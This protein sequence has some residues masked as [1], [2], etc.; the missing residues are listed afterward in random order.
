MDYAIVRTGGKQYKVSSGDVLDVEKLPASKGDRIELTDV[1]LLSHEG[2]VTV[3]SPT[4][5]GAK[6]IGEVEEQRRGEKLVVFRYKSKTRQGT[7]TGH[8][9]WLTRLRIIEILSG[10]AQPSRRRRRSDASAHFLEA[11]TQPP[12]RRRRSTA[13]STA[14]VEEAKDGP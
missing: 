12:R 9:Q 8:R 1:L 2:S 11:I 5:M 10:G 13:R 14:S 3:G 4:V 7:K 6:V